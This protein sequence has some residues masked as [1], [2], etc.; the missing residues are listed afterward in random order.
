MTILPIYLHPHPVLRQ[1]A[2]P[3]TEVDDNIRRLLDDMV[4]TM[5]NAN[6]VGLAAPQVGVSKRVIVLHPPADNRQN[7]SQYQDQPLL[8][9]NPEIT[10]VSREKVTNEE[11]CLSIP[12]L[13]T[14][15]TRPRSI[16]L[17]YLDEHGTRQSMAPEEGILTFSIQH[18]IDHLNGILFPDHL[19]RL[20]R[21]M[22]WK[23]YQ[24]ILPTVMEALP[25]PYVAG[26]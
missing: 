9:I 13:Y 15:V 4:K 7:N 11:G 16:K 23:R 25:Y 20:K 18:E 22:T 8:M 10:E 2:T 14:K 24:K 6:G 5:H 21:E 17:T 26:E 3:V 1:P 12:T 19:S